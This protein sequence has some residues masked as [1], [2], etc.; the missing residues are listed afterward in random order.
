MIL[1]ARTTP[2]GEVTKKSEGMS[3][4]IVD[5]HQASARA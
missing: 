5:L 3:I 2:L 4:F 1:L